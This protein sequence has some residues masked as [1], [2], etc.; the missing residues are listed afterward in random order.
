MQEDGSSP[1]GRG[2]H[3]GSWLVLL[4]ERFIPARAGNSRSSFT[5]FSVSSVHPRAGGELDH[6]GPRPFYLPGSS[7]RGR[8]T[9]AVARGIAS[10]RRFIPA[11]AGNSSGCC[12]GRRPISVHP[13]AGGELR[14][15]A[16]TASIW[17]GSSP[18]GRGTLLL[19]HGIRPTLR[20]IPARAGN[21]YRLCL[22]ARPQAV[23]PRAGGELCG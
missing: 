5:C 1:R 18:R 13:R 2:T 10:C 8:G 22:G 21:S 16:R 4:N 23:H 11:R 17:S 15:L 7:P 19:G 9:P 14:D 20:F 12:R 3:R 6:A